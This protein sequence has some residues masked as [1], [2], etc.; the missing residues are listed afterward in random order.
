MRKKLLLSAIC[1]SLLCSL[2]ACGK[3]EKKDDGGS[4][5]KIESTTQM[6]DEAEGRTAGEAIEE[7]EAETNSL[8]EGPGR[9]WIM[10]QDLTIPTVST[11]KEALGAEINDVVD[12]RAFLE[13]PFGLEDVEG[14]LYYEVGGVG[15][16]SLE[17]ALADEQCQLMIEPGEDS[18]SVEHISFGVT[19]EICD[20]GYVPTVGFLY[21]INPTDKAVSYRECIENKW[22]YMDN[23]YEDTIIRGY[24]KDTIEDVGGDGDNYDDEDRLA[25][26]VKMFGAPTYFDCPQTKE[27]QAAEERIDEFVENYKKDNTIDIYFVGWEFEEYVLVVQISDGYYGYW[28][29][30]APGG[31]YYSRELWDELKLYNGMDYLKSKMN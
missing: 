21:V 13:Y 15:Y 23:G 27:G 29:L 25:N 22:F 12:N 31:A 16:S 5:G 10:E 14:Y 1:I 26:Y 30:R 28:A 3:D 7:A 8:S 6:T 19:T 18:Y 20:H 11:P 9:R 24:D 17:E 2:A 4:A